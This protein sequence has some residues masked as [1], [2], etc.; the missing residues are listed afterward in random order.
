MLALGW[1]D[2]HTLI[3][4]DFALLGSLKSQIS[5]IFQ[6][7]DKRTIGYK[8]HLEA[9]CNRADSANDLAAVIRRNNGFVY[10]Y[11]QLVYLC[12]IN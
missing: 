12:P 7:I 9:S 10:A 8:R 3:P 1:S 5:G 4:V 6:P 11:G 2:G